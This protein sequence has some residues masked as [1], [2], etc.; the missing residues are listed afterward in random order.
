MRACENI[1]LSDFSEL[2]EEGVIRLKKFGF[3]NVTRE[4]VLSDEVY[5]FFLSRFVSSLKGKCQETD[6]Q[7]NRLQKLLEGKFR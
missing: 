3:I 4:N 7:I 1:N 5:C 2:I 6:D